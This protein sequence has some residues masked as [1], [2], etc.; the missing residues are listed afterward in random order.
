MSENNYRPNSHKFREEA[1]EP[2]K[3]IEKVATGKIKK[4]SSIRKFSDVF[5]SEDVSN[6]KNY[7]LMEVLVPAVKKAFSDVITNGIDMLLYGGNGRA[8]KNNGNHT[9]YVSYNRFSDRKDEPPRNEVRRGYSHDD[10]ILE[11]RRDAEAVINQMFGILDRYK[12]VTV[13]DL[14]DL[15]G[16]TGSHT[17]QK[18]GWTSLRDVDIIHV[19]E[20]YMIRMPRA[21][22]LD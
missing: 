22:P 1:K 6:V 12:M 16:V 11:T 15:V 2:E 14:Y 13:F 5:V 7:I 9:S 4:K 17:D 20:G 3:K 18:Y 19:R 8:N 10:V 21:C